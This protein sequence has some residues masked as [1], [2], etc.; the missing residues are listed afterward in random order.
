[1]L[2]LGGMA[3]TFSKLQFDESVVGFDEAVCA[4]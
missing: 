1:M 2:I 4:L 3:V